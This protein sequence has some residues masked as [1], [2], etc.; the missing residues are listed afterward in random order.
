MWTVVGGV[1]RVRRAFIHLLLCVEHLVNVHF[2]PIKPCKEHVS[3][4][5]LQMERV[6]LREIT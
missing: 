5:I 3:I 4:S 6:T 1:K 2:I